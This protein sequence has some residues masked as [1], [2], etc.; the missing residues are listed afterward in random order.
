MIR[1]PPR[2]TLTVTLVPYT[3]LFRSDDR[4]AGRR[5][6]DIPRGSACQISLLAQMAEQHGHEVR[7]APGSEHSN[8]VADRPDRNADQPLLQAQAD[9]GGDRAIYDRNASRRP[10]DQDRLS[11]AGVG[12]RLD[13]RKMTI[14][15]VVYATR[16]QK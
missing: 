11:Q 1:R 9:R 4:Q 12:R 5:A 10:T 13:A 6:T 7:V 2:S 16:Q 14:Y 3:T 8:A 15:D